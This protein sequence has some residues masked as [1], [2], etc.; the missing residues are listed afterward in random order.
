MIEPGRHASFGVW[1]PAWYGNVEKS[2]GFLPYKPKAEP[3][4]AELQPLLDWARPFYE[5]LHAERLQVEPQL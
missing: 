4:P 1:A 3:F 2:T 5:E